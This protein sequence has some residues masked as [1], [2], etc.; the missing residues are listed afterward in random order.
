M[1]NTARYQMSFMQTKKN[2]VGIVDDFFS[3]FN[4]FINIHKGFMY[5]SK[6]IEINKDAGKMQQDLLC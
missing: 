1:G 6:F 2:Q 5:L 4:I 3:Y